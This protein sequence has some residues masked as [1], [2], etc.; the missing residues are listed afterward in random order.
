MSWSRSNG[1]R[2]SRS[3]LLTKVRMGVSRIRQTSMS[4]RVR[5]STPLT[6]SMTMRAESTAVRTRKVS[7][8]KSSWPGVSS[9]FT[10]RSS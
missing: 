6:E 2:P 5:L 8:E 7:S 3:S 4:C 10:T 9:R 1:S